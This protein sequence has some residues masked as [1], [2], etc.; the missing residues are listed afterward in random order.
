MLFFEITAIASR[1]S[2]S[3]D[4]GENTAR[5]R[6]NLGG[7]IVLV[8]T[9]SDYLS[10]CKLFTTC[11]KR[12]LLT[13]HRYESQMPFDRKNPSIDVSVVRGD[14]ASGRKFL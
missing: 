14:D 10:T 9:L 7:R 13:A 12:G 5:E 8:G 6:H 1:T 11:D 4:V 2:R 3:T